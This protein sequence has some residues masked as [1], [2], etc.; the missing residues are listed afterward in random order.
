MQRI[1]QL[2]LAERNLKK[3][4]IKKS[5]IEILKKRDKKQGKK[6]KR[7]GLGMSATDRFGGPSS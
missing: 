5:C 6:G 4:L 2:A 1:S 3:D 7:N